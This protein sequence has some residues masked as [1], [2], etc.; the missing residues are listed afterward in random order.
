MHVLAFTKIFS[1]NGTIVLVSRIEKTV[2]YW[3]HQRV[4][5]VP[6]GASPFLRVSGTAVTFFSHWF[7]FL[8]LFVVLNSMRT[9]LRYS[10]STYLQ[11][12]LIGHARPAEKVLFHPWPWNGPQPAPRIMTK[13]EVCLTSH[14][15]PISSFICVAVRPITTRSLLSAD[16]QAQRQGCLPWNRPRWEVAGC[17][18]VP[19]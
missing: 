3:T 8:S 14:F 6:L 9:L 12:K 7:S 19:I 17:R 1:F 4:I 11:I 5:Q 16:E 2:L 10:I 13:P 15:L 18:F